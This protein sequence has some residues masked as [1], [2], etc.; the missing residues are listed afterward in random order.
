MKIFIRSSWYRSFM[1]YLIRFRSLLSTFFESLPLF[2]SGTHSSMQFMLFLSQQ[3]LLGFL[4]R[5]LQCFIW[6]YNRQLFLLI[7]CVDRRYMRSIYDN[8]CY[9]LLLKNVTA[10]NVNL[11]V[12]LTLS[13]MLWNKILFYK[14]DFVSFVYKGRFSYS[15]WK[16]PRILPILV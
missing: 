15:N 5:T 14:N 2:E 7:K 1:F 11:F 13:L 9:A 10:M 12:K 3:E 8:T 16:E 4:C 6:L